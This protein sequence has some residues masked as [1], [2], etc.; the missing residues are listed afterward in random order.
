[1]PWPEPS[2]VL[3]LPAAPALDLSLFPPE[4]AN[5]S[6]DASERLQAPPDYLAWGN[7]VTVAGLI[8]RRAGIRPRQYDDWTE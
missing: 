2:R 4:I 5:V 1:M 3:G 8:G 6:A 7:V